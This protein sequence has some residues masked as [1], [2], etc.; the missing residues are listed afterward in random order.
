[1]LHIHQLKV[2]NLQGATN[3]ICTVGERKELAVRSYPHAGLG[4]IKKSK[5]PQRIW[6]VLIL[7]CFNTQESVAALLKITKEC[8]LNPSATNWQKPLNNHLLSEQKE[9]HIGEVDNQPRS[10]LMT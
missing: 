7:S 6:K 10:K 4:V 2:K 3:F 1:M 8:L 5:G 9:S